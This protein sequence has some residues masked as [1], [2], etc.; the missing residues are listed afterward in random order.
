MTSYTTYLP[1]ISCSSSTLATAAGSRRRKHLDAIQEGCPCQTS[2][3]AVFAWRSLRGDGADVAALALTPLCLRQRI[4]N[5]TV[6]TL[7]HKRCCHSFISR[8]TDFAARRW[9]LL[10]PP[11]YTTFTRLHTARGNQRTGTLL[12]TAALQH[13]AAGRLD[14]HLEHSCIVVSIPYH[15]TTKLG[16][17][18][19]FCAAPLLPLECTCLP[20]LKVCLAGGRKEEVRQHLCLRLQHGILL[21]QFTLTNYHAC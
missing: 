15:Q 7:K 13:Y 14:C 12:P 19:H 18:Y 2:R 5:C 16:V 20:S 17:P 11:T 10:R 4:T 21:L 9:R 6:A 3:I 8:T 1:T